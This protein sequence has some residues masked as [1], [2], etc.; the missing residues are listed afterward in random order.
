MLRIW[1]TAHVYSICKEV[2]DVYALC[3]LCRPWAALYWDP[4]RVAAHGNVDRVL[5]AVL[6]PPQDSLS[7]PS[8]CSGGGAAPQTTHV[9]PDRH[10]HVTQASEGG[11]VGEGGWQPTICLEYPNTLTAHAAGAATVLQSP[12]CA[13]RPLEWYISH[14]SC[15]IPPRCKASQ[16]S[17]A[18]RQL[19]ERKKTHDTVAE[20]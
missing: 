3:C 7:L 16:G 14:V 1:Y 6:S 8:L 13:T 4:A 17:S 15:H 12:C 19:H 10:D 2:N 9:T 5:S 11:T 18:C 20:N